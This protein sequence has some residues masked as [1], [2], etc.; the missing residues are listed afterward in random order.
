MVCLYNLLHRQGD[1][2][3]RGPNLQLKN[4]GSKRRV[5][6]LRKNE[7]GREA[8]LEWRFET[9]VG[10]MDESMDWEG[11]K[12][13]PGNKEAPANWSVDNMAQVQKMRSA[14]QKWRR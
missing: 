1:Q 3:L 8:G 13:P 9:L 2:G 4:H 12:A 7:G 10:D 5:R 11:K 6:D 14:I